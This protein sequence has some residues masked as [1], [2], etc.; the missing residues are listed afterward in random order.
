MKRL[1]ILTIFLLV[2]GISQQSFSQTGAVHPTRTVRAIYHDMYGPLSDLPS[3]TKVEK[4]DMRDKADQKL[5]N[6]A[7]RNRSYPFAKTALPK[8]D[9]ALWQKTMGTVRNGKTPILNFEGQDSP[10][11]PPDANLSVGP[12]HVMQTV[13]T[14]YAIY[15]K[16]GAQV[17]AP[18]AMNTLFSGVPGS[19][20]N[21]GDPL[22]LFDSQADKWLAVELSYSSGNYMLVAVSQTNDP[23]GVWD[24]WSFVMNGMPDY[25]KIGIWQDGYY[26]ATNTGNGD[27]VYV[28]ER[29]EMINGGPTPQMVQ[30]DNPWRPTTIDGFHCILPLDNDGVFA[31][32]GSPG[33]YITINDDAIGGGADELWVY[34][35]DIDWTT[36]ANSTF[37]RTEQLSVSPFDSDFGNSWDNI[38]QPGTSQ[39]LDAIP[40]ILM[41]RA[42]Y[43]N[44]G[45]SQA[46][47]CTHTVDL[48]GSDHAGI[49]WYELEN[50]T[51][52]WGVRQQ[53]TYGPDADSRWLGSIAMNASHEIAIGYSISSSTEYPGIRYVGQTSGE[54]STASGTLDV[55]EDIIQTGANSQTGANRWGDYANMSVDPAD[56]ETFWFTTEYLGSGGYRKTK[57]ASFQIGPAVLAANFSA[58]KTQ[59]ELGGL[60][61]FADLS[62][63]PPTSWSWSF[64]GGTPSSYSGENPPPIQYDVEGFYDVSLEVSDGSTTDIMTKTDYIEVIDCAISTFPY[65]EEFENGGNIPNCWIQ[66][67][68][69]GSE[70]D[71]QFITGNGDSNPVAA[72]SGTYNACLKDETA[73]SEITNLITPMLDLSGLS[74]AWL[75]FWH[76]QEQWVSDQDELLLYY[77][78]SATGNWELLASYT[79]E[80]TNWTKDSIDLPELSASYYIAF[81]GNAKYGYGVCIDDVKIEGATAVIEAEFSADPVSGEAPLTVDFDDQSSG[82]ITSWDWDFGD[83]NTSTEQFP[84][85]TYND[86]GIY[87][88]SLTVTGPNGSDTETKVDFIV[89]SSIPAP[90]ANFE[91]DPLSGTEPLQVNFSDL[92]TG[93]ISTWEWD[94]GDGG[95]SSEQ[96]PVYNY[97]DAGLY[98]VSLTI[99]GP[100]GS[101]NKTITDYIEV[102]AIEPPVAEFE[103]NPTT[104]SAP[105]QVSFNN[106][107]T[108][109]IEQFHWDFGDGDNSQEENP[110]HEYLAVGNYTVALKVTGSNGTD[111]E[112]K[113]DYILIP[114]G[115]EDNTDGPFIVFPNPVSHNLNVTFPDA[116]KRELRLINN[117]G[118]TILALSSS[119]REDKVQMENLPSGVYWL[120]VLEDGILKATVRVIRK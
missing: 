13:N 80:I 32:A 56:D 46:I 39:K 63:G 111:T 112:T 106:L 96:N 71:W 48:D 16:A 59:V 52:S 17:V 103:G 89:V 50:T 83:G 62:S 109:E 93:D 26:M 4:L 44:F 115:I 99:Q 77:K 67:Y 113:T 51:G 10:Y 76:T 25:E 95:T 79:S 116:R 118:V 27:D 55:A 42:Q 45:S 34:E 94:F 120:S 19:S 58:D 108:G 104:G 24:R 72:H 65:F 15:N 8:G 75:T 74:S 29:D 47:V 85:N 91:G 70:V 35:C 18:T 23:S 2:A 66:E 40:M 68:V 119:S 20:Q 82:N 88:V 69:S 37:N 87:T 11:Y 41:Y 117:A 33:L 107:S 61:Q 102:L 78:T 14:T 7:L 86:E 64:P 92:S 49:R 22:I 43:R 28:F 36:P 6:A 38:Q 73:D 3:L 110:V 98:T 114:V 100:G 84:T 101:N 53:G 12:N 90:V 57:I 54:N 1:T 9:D 31:P 5:L 30:F 81:Q 60:V 105:L 97:L 21:D